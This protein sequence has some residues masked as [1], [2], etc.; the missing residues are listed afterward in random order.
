MNE[1]RYTN[2]RILHAGIQGSCIHTCK[3]TYMKTRTNT[4]KMHTR[5]Y[6]HMHMYLLITLG[7]HFV[8]TDK[9]FSFC[10]SV[11]MYVC[12]YV[13]V[14]SRMSVASCTEIYA[15]TKL[16]IHP[17]IVRLVTLQSNLRHPRRHDTSM[18]TYTHA[19][20]HTCADGAG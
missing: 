11:C 12:M 17:R 9:T 14:H 13:C 20:T 10:A 19:Y 6:M 18:R 7:Q 5:T 16:F 3:Y 15:R 2:I 8:D 4:L 1:C